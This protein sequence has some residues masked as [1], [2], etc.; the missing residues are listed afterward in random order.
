MKW[1]YN[2]FSQPLRNE[3]LNLAKDKEMLKKNKIKNQII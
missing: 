2:S 1:L 3:G